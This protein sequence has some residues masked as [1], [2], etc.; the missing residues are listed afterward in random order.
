VKLH[1]SHA[2]GQNLFTGYGTDYVAVNN[3][4]YGKSVVVTPDTV[5]VWDAAEFDRI[6]AADFEPAVTANPEIVIFGTGTMQRFP[7]PE[8]ARSLAAKGIGF[9]VMDSRAACRTY[10]ILAAEGR[11]VVAAILL[12]Q[13]A[14]IRER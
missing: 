5:T 9:E 14:V 7:R 10:N 11:R 4:R 3:M 2:T 6:A 12:D 1:L 13:E 8:V